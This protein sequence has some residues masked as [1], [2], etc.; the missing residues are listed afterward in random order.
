TGVV[1]QLVT[2]HGLKLDDNGFIVVNDFKQTSVDG[3]Y[4][5]GDATMRMQSAINAAAGAM[6]AAAFPMDPAMR[7]LN[8]VRCREARRR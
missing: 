4:A 1:Q 5:F 6:M 8:T 7:G 3:L 2:S